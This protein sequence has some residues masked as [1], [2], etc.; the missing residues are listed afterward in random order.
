MAQLR[1]TWKR[2]TIGRPD[3]QERIIRALGL[4]RLHHTVI[5][6]D[7]PAIRGM[8]REVEHLLEWSEV[9]K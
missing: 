6:E 8:V 3:K 9:G 2:S 1:L 4:K 7:T 5:Q